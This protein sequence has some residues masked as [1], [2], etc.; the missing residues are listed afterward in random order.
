[1]PTLNLVHQYPQQSRHSFYSMDRSW[2]C[3]GNM[4]EGNSIWGCMGCVEELPEAP[5][6]YSR[7]DPMSWFP[8]AQDFSMMMFVLKPPDT[9]PWDVKTLTCHSDHAHM[10]DGDT[11]NLRRAS[12]PTSKSILSTLG[13]SVMGQEEGFGMNTPQII[14]NTSMKENITTSWD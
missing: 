11:K 9:L 7:I 13:K 3:L 1:M 10:A 14:R 2:K 6:T 8:S 5:V 4:S 12:S